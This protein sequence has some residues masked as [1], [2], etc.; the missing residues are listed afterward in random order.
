MSPKETAGSDKFQKVFYGNNPEAKIKMY[1]AIAEDE[2]KRQEK[3]SGISPNH[4]GT[5]IKTI[6]N[7]ETGQVSEVDKEYIPSNARA[8][9]M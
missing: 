2:K 6:I 3:N 9:R 5:I 1:E 7:L 8:R 4:H